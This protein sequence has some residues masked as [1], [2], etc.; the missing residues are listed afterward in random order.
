MLIIG[1]HNIKQL[2]NNENWSLCL[3]ALLGS[4]NKLLIR[5]HINIILA[6]SISSN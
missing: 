4:H 6:I 1:R 2:V 3:S 5:M